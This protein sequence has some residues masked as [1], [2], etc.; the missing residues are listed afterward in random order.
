M[1]LELMCLACLVSIPS[2]ATADAVPAGGWMTRDCP[3]VTCPAGSNPYGGSHGSCSIGCSPGQTCQDDAECARYYDES[4]RCE[5]TRFC[6]QRVYGGNSSN[7]VVRGECRPD[8]T[9][10]QPSADPLAG[11]AEPIRCELRSRCVFHEELGASVMR[12]E[13][14]PSATSTAMTSTTATESDDEESSCAAASS[15]GGALWLLACLLLGRRRY[16]QRA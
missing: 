15:S 10:E 13:P 6:I 16:S 8:D 7:D 3:P 4:F 5:P 9:C 2:I 1:K 12:A 14:Q 11:D